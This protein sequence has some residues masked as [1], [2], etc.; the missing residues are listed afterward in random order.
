MKLHQLKPPAFLALAWSAHLLSSGT[1]LQA[2]NIIE[3]SGG[4]G[5]FFSAAN[6]TGGVVPVATDIA[7]I[8][9][10]STAT[11]GAAAGDRGL[12]CLRLGDTQD[13]TVSGHVVMDGGFF[14][15]GET[16]GDPKALIG[17]SAVLSSFIMNGGTIFFDG[18]DLNP[19]NKNGK[20]VNELDWE[21][22]ERGKGR[23]EMHNNAIFRASDD[24][25][26]AENAAGDGYCLLDGNA[27]VTLGSGLSISAGGEVEQ[28]MVMGGN[29]R[30][31]SGNSMGAGDP[32]GQTDEGYLTM[33]TGG[34]K[35]KLTIQENAVMNIRRLT[36]REGFSTIIVKDH[37]QFH[38]FDVFAGRGYIDANTPPDRPAETGPN[39]AYGSAG[40]SEAT[41]TLQD[42]A[43]MTVN[44]NPESGPTHGLGISSPRDSGNAGGLVKMIIRDRASFR[45]EQ[46]LEVGTGSAETS[47]GTVTVIGKDVSVAIGGN[48]NLAVDM[49]GFPTAGRGTLNP[50]ITSGQHATVAIG[51]IAN[52]ANGILK[53]TLQDHTPTAGTAYTILTAG[54]VVGPFKEVDWTEAP[55]PEGL[56]WEIDYANTNRVVIAVTAGPAPEVPE[57]G[58]M[59]GRYPDFSVTSVNWICQGD[60]DY[61]GQTLLDI[62]SQGPVAWSC[63]K[64]NR[65]DFAVRLSPADPAAARHNLGTLADWGNSLSSDASGMVWRPHREKG[66]IIPTARQNGPIDWNDGHGGFYPTVASSYSSSGS[67]YSM[68]D[69]IF[70]NGDTDV[71]TGKAGG[72]GSPWAEADFNFATT[73]FPY[74]QGWIAGVTDNPD[75]ATGEGRWASLDSHTPG[76]AETVLTG[77]DLGT[78]IFGGSVVLNLPGVNSL[79][80]GMLFT[81]SAQGNSDCNITAAAP[82]PDGAGWIVTIREDAEVDPQVAAT[83]GVSGGNESQFQFVYIPW[84]AGNLVGGFINGDTGAKIKGTGTY[85]LVRTGTGTYELSIP[86]KT[87]KD[88]AL[89]LENAEMLSGSTTLADNNFFSYEFNSGS[90]KF[91]I[92]ARHTIAGNSAALQDTDFCFAWIDFA[93]PPVPAGAVEI[94]PTLTLTRAGANVVISWP[95]ASAGYTLE[96]SATMAANSWTAVGGV[97][98][99]SV[100]VTPSGAQVFYRLRK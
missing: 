23:F 96:S 47:D 76:L 4:N 89:L 95:T 73:W 100:T 58:G 65:G 41:L 15:I 44:S 52:L 66:V 50:V 35:S 61:D 94:P 54:Q 84:T 1:T 99:N 53:V 40:T 78:G 31:D 49:D 39:S 38:I 24:L 26:I 85:T 18:P 59:P 34:G 51:G 90:G 86:G 97:A 36:A 32:N 46:N 45:V 56:R 11:I 92:Q 63:T 25:K 91:V 12:G 29:A 22:G 75:P 5:D 83:T 79:N 8:N 16:P 30:L 10:G 20:G 43:Q 70:G 13:G 80:D 6:W 93:N 88:G 48:L 7:L 57:G 14:R 2:Q 68:V 71:Q 72:S 87:G 3:W 74:A 19:G 62:D 37:G 17:F 98:N 27:L 60:V 64:I 69:G 42:D 81:T 28:T 55:L 9:N 21:V 33:A 67:G 82:K 77:L